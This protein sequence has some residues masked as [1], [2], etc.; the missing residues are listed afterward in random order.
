MTVANNLNLILHWGTKVPL[1]NVKLAKIFP[2]L[3]P[4]LVLIVKLTHPEL[5]LAA[6][7]ISFKTPAIK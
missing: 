2:W 7:F 1:M 4:Y 6:V 5:V 3:L